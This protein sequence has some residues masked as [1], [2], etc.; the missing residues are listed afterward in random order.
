MD[1][2]KL[3]LARNIIDKIDKKIFGLIKKR[4]KIVTTLM[5]LKKSKKEIVDQKRINEILKKIKNKS[6]KA[7]IDQKTTNKIWKSIIW[8]YVDLQRRKFKKK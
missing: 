8:S 5:K 3:K 6:I 7:G 1:K 2:N 4:T